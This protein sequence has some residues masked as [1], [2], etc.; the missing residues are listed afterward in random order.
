MATTMVS[1]ISTTR[2]YRYLVA[3]P[4]YVRALS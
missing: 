4:P 3:S 1:I 2:E